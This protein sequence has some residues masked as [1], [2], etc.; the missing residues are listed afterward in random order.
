VVVGDAAGF[1]NP[2]TR[3]GV[4]L[5][6]LSGKLAAQA[7]VRAAARGDFSAASL[8]RYRELVDDSVI[9]EDL[10]KIRNVTPFAHERPH[11]F[12]DYP[13]LASAVAREYLTVDGSSKKEKQRRIADMI[14]D[15]PKRR[16]LGDLVGAMRSLT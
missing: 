11:L 1:V 13:E 2:L 9:M 6:M 5:A 12:R 4:N 7:I 10:H 15:V 8:S 3:E 16:L 14:R